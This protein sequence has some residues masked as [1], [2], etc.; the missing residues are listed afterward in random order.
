MDIMLVVVMQ[1]EETAYF[2]ECRSLANL[3]RIVV[4]LECLAINAGLC[5]LR[6]ASG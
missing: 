6:D 1:C 3:A 5:G 2:G 4:T